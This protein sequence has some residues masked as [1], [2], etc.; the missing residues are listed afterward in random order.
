MEAKTSSESETSLAGAIG[1]GFAMLALL[2]IILG[3]G[4]TALIALIVIGAIVFG[5][6]YIWRQTISAKY[7]RQIADYKA[8]LEKARLSQE[9]IREAA[10]VDEM[11]VKHAEFTKRCV[12]MM[13]QFADLKAQLADKAVDVAVNKQAAISVATEDDIDNTSSFLNTDSTL[14]DNSSEEKVDDENG[15]N[16][17]EGS[18]QK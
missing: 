11:L 17:N 13:D 9:R 3:S 4:G 7:D 16:P 15:K 14:S 6:P 1:G 18:N 2:A 8:E 12:Q 5:V 10:A